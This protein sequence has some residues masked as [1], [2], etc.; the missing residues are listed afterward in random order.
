MRLWT[1]HKPD[2][3]LLDGQVNH[4]RSEY[5]QTILGVREAYH[6]LAIGATL[7]QISALF[8]HTTPRW[9]GFS[10]CPPQ[11]S[12]LLP[13]TLSGIESLASDAVCRVNLSACG[14]TNHSSVTHTIQLLGTGLSSHDEMH[15]G[16][17]HPRPVGGG[18]VSLW[19]ND[20]TSLSQRLFLIRC[21]M[22]R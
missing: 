7:S 5:V 3:S 16:I 22:N 21:A 8:S 17:K 20:L 11:K 13:T 2:F 15:S 12:W 19:M 4:E 18:T 1:W 14:R 9:S 6:E 10:K